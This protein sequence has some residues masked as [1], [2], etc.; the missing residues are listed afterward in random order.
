MLEVE[1]TR[2]FSFITWYHLT[3]L[4]ISLALLGYGAAGSFL[5]IRSDLRSADYARILGLCCLLF[6]LL[7]I[8]AVSASVWF[9]VSAEG[10]F[11]GKYKLIAPIVLTHTVLAIPFFLAGTTIGFV[12][13]RNRAE[14][15][16]LYSADLLGAGIG[17][18]LSVVII[19]YLGAIS[20][21]YLAAALPAFVALAA[22]RKSR[23]VL[24]I[25]AG[26]VLFLIVG[27][28]ALSVKYEV[29]HVRITPEKDLKQYQIIFTKWNILNRIDVVN[30]RVVPFHFGGRLSDAYQGRA[31]MILPI[32][33]DGTAPTALVHVGGLAKD[34]P[35][36][37]YF[38]QSAPYAVHP[39]PGQVLILGVGGGI[40][41][42]IAQRGG[43]G[44]IVGVD[45]NPVT[46]DLLSRR[47]RWFSADLFRPDN[48][49]LVVSEGRHYLTKTASKFDVIQLSGVDTWAA[50]SGGS[51]VLT[52]SYL[53]TTEAIEALLSHLNNEGILSYSRWLFDPPR[54]TLK[55]VV[56]ECEALRGTG[57]ADPGRHFLIVAGGPP[58]GRW[59]DTM[60][61]KTAFTPEEISG[62]RS[63]AR[64]KQFDIIYDPTEGHANFFNA[65]LNAAEDD[66]KAFMQSYPYDISASHD[67][68]PFFFQFFRWRNVL[69]PEGAQ[70][71]GGHPGYPVGKIPKGLLSLAVALVELSFLSIVFVLLPLI[72]RRTSDLP[73]RQSASWLLAFAGLGIGFMAVEMVLIQKLSVFLGGP[74]YSMAVTLCALLIF[75]GLGSRVSQGLSRSGYRAATGMIIGIILV[76]G[77]ELVILDRGVPALLGFAHTWRCIMAILA[78]APMGFL[79]GM[80]FPTLLAKSGEASET[81]LPWA[82]GTN[83]CATVVGSV[84]ATISSITMGFNRTWLVAM[85]MY[86]GVLIIVL[87]RLM[88]E[89]RFVSDP[90]SH[91]VAS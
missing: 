35:L 17:S 81:L 38:V 77:L 58:E 7:T 57:V 21:I 14:A 84:L 88:R 46:I 71:V 20:A 63:W 34:C 52:E 67:D 32:F 83:A 42:L 1:L 59:A 41:A 44:H 78:I 29:I 45:I 16:R 62:L 6:S 54:E 18:L 37:D 26:V 49:D 60:V 91:A 25:L 30:P 33:Q 68:H 61:K 89:P 86:V 79:M 12:L 48:L 13:M 76:Q 80:P 85:A 66:Q 28:A 74:A 19:K 11:E 82:W 39:R 9:P 50:L 65:Y 24:K 4:V 55:L 53:Y 2:L 43:A 72:A 36:F 23:P 8:L 27:A 40:D 3:Y 31:P 87:G 56:T 64:E 5:A 75:S 22:F 70:G 69:H 73:F 15:N 90:D 47:Y 51:Y 10:F